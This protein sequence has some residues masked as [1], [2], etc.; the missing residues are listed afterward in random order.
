M[1]IFVVIQYS[2]INIIGDITWYLY[3]QWWTNWGLFT[4]INISCHVKLHV[5]GLVLL[6]L[7]WLTFDSSVGTRIYLA[8][9]FV[10]SSIYLLFIRLSFTQDY[11]SNDKFKI[12]DDRISH[13]LPTSYQDMI[14]RV[15]SKKPELVCV[16]WCKTI[17]IMFLFMFPNFN[18][19]PYNLQVEAI[20]EA[21]ENFQLKTYG[22]KT[23]V[24]ATPEKKK[25]RIWFS[26]C[27]DYLILFH[28]KTDT[29]I[30]SHRHDYVGS[31]FWH[32]LLEARFTRNCTRHTVPISNWLSWRILPRNSFWSA[33]PIVNL[34]GQLLKILYLR[35]AQCRPAALVCETIFDKVLFALLSFWIQYFTSFLLFSCL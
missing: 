18:T 7:H 1:W 33:S 13:L 24:H 30:S 20:S 31:W 11:E 26:C 4:G 35:N 27:W 25:R 19:F 28:K 5:T 32:F 16:L 17:V 12:S 14:V 21:F 15:Y 34:L 29:S 10:L 6:F 2:K 3:S 8:G 22:I 9:C 23:Q